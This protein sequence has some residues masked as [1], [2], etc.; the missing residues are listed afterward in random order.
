MTSVFLSRRMVHRASL[1][2][3]GALDDS[4]PAFDDV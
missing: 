2:D 1:E 3:P 4:G